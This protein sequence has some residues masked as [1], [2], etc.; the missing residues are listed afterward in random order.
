M[1]KSQPKVVRDPSRR[2]PKCKISRARIKAICKKIAQGVPQ[3]YAAVCCGIARTTYFRW[4]Q[5]GDELIPEGIQP[6]IE[7][8]L[9]RELRDAVEKAKA[10]A[11]NFHIS[12]INLAARRGN[13]KASAWRL[14]SLDKEEFSTKTQTEFTGPE[15]GDIP[16]AITISA[17]DQKFSQVLKRIYGKA[18]GA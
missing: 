17:A 5:E 2:G 10:E 15:G 6:T 12:K 1:K 7:Q 13:W 9:T 18:D 14:Q 16:V 3:Q 8:L 11:I 4:L